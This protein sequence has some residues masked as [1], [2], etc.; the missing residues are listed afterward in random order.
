MGRAEG[1]GWRGL[2]S[3]CSAHQSLVP[4][5]I[6]SESQ[7]NREQL[8]ELCAFALRKNKLK[9]S[10]KSIAISWTLLWTGTLSNTTP[11]ETLPSSDHCVQ[12]RP[13]NSR[14]QVWA[15]AVT[16]VRQ[17]MF[18]SWVAAG[19]GKANLLRQSYWMGGRAKHR[20]FVG[21]NTAARQAAPLGCQQDRV[22]GPGR[23]LSV[24]LF[25]TSGIIFFIL[26]VCQ[27]NDSILRGAVDRDSWRKSLLSTHTWSFLQ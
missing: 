27:G 10:S 15:V 9:S 25:L 22:G 18:A 3:K 4:W 21:R 5:G 16:S 11:W 24:L 20:W 13:C 23:T 6:P 19:R 26:W 12:I 1:E 2:A 7:Q 17:G 8:E 14:R